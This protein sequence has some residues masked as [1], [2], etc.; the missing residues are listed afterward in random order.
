MVPEGWYTNRETAESTI[1]SCLAYTLLVPPSVPVEDGVFFRWPSDALELDGTPLIAKYER[2]YGIESALAGEVQ[3]V[4]GMRSQ[5]SV[6]DGRVSTDAP[7]DRVIMRVLT[8]D[9]G[10]EGAVEV[11]V[12]S[13]RPSPSS[14]AIVIGHPAG[15][16]VVVRADAA[17]DPRAVDAGRAL[18]K[19]LVLK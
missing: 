9:E 16:V 13:Q 19:S 4:L 18:V 7:S 6:A 11:A 1:Q 10:P 15:G 5:V 14:W 2:S 8:R 3:A 17:I 12:E